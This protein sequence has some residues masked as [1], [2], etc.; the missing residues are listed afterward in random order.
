[1]RIG[2]FGGTFDPL[3]LAHLRVAEEVAERQR[4]DKVIFIPAGRP[5]HRPAPQASPEHRLAMVRL[6]IAGNPRFAVSDCEIKRP[7]PSFTVD[8]LAVLKSGHPRDSLFLLMGMDQL[9]ELHAWHEVS[10]LLSLCRVVAFSRPGQPLP[11]PGSIPGPGRAALPS[12]AYT[13]QAV[14]ALEISATL[15]RRRVRRGE[16]LRYLL[17]ETVIRYLHQHQL[18]QSRK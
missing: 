5:P 6:G 10:R 13:I 17:P 7:G 4:L 2:I 1:M 18:Y 12:R 8:T 3:H 14:S 15:I 16:S 11:Q 9:R